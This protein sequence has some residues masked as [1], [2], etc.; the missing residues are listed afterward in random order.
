M[1][2]FSFLNLIK[3]NTL[4]VYLVLLGAPLLSQTSKS[5]Q[6]LKLEYERLKADDITI[7][8]DMEQTPLNLDAPDEVEIVHFTDEIAFP[9][10]YKENRLKHFGYNFFTNRDTIRFWENLPVPLN[11]NLGPGDELILSLW[12]ETQI[13]Q[14]YIISR[15]GKI[16]D[17]KVGLLILSGKTLSEAKDYLKTQFGR[18]YSTLKEPSPSTYIDLSIGDLRSINVN[19]VGNVNFPGIYPLNPY[20]NLMTGLISAGGVDTTGSLR[21]IQIKRDNKIYKTVDLYEFLIYGGI[22]DSLILRNQDI[23]IVPARKSIVEI[24]SAV[25][26]PGIYETKEMETVDELIKHAGGFKNNASDIISV[27]RILAKNERKN[28]KSFESSYISRLEAK[29]FS[30]NLLR[31]VS[32]Q[33]L[34]EEEQYV[35]IIG[36]V[37]FPGKY[38]F[39]KDMT[40]SSL[41][42][43]SSGFNDTTFIKSVFL[44]QGEIIR[45]QPDQRYDEVI[46]F[47]VK[48]VKDNINDLF[49]ENLDRVVIHANLNYFEKKPVQILGEVNIPGNYPVLKDNESLRTFINRAGGFTE[50]SFIEGIKIYRDS[51][52]VAWKNLSI[53]LKPGDSVVIQ[54]KPGTV[55]VSGEVYNPGLIEY[56]KNKSMKNY[57][58]LAGGLTKNGDKNDILIIYPNGEVVPSSRFF[59]KTIRDGSIIIVNEKIDTEPFNPTAFANNTLSLLSSLV[60]ILVLSK[61]I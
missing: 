10:I 12:G 21:N 14:S 28:G 27:K 50:R 39:Y 17:D 61:Q 58:N 2:K 9:F 44:S 30:T 53:P 7:P 22:S 40:L 37:K 47:D 24:D 42:N 25:V 31:S 54:Q 13:R 19:F 57:I 49:L 33:P 5:I 6:Q 29:S 45:R 41:F 60:T 59:S 32:V 46:S 52:S 48:D 38:S 1:M 26:N 15:D 8:S 43:L 3:L 4:F 35:E 20:S 55:F 51:L 56:D 34:M 36:Q 18:V 16:Y 11:Y 23:V